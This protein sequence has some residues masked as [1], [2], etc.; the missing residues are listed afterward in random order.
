MS[1]ES[2]G[3]WEVYGFDIMIDQNLRPWLIEVNSSPACDYSTEVTEKFVRKA[4]PDTLKV[5]L[6]GNSNPNLQS[7]HRGGWQCIYCGMII[8]KVI[9]GLGVDLTLKGSK[10]SNKR[11]RNKGKH[12]TKKQ[13]IDLDKDP[14]FDDSDLSEYEKSSKGKVSMEAEKTEKTT[15]DYN[16]ENERGNGKRSEVYQ[17]AKVPLKKYCLNRKT[18]NVHLKTMVTLPLNKVTI[19]F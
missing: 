7:V 13:V 14:L 11:S 17:S 4:L 15:K 6:D 9:V 2:K 19:D 5:I 12:R 1:V 10:I 18:K 16:K 3:C 8:P